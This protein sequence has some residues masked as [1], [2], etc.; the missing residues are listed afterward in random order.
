MPAQKKLG[1]SI[2]AEGTEL[3]AFSAGDSGD[4]ISLTDIARYKS[5]APDDVIKTDA[6]P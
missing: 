4:D 2:Y 5:D 1:E 6:Q 3:A